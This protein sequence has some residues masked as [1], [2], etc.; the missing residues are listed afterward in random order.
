[1]ID[2]PGCIAGRF[3]SPSPARGPELNNL[4]SLQIFE[5]FTAQRLRTPDH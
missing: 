2:E 4:K 5:S 3:I 1:M